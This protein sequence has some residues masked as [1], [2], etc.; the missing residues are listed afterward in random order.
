MLDL[1]NVTLSSLLFLNVQDDV[2]LDSSVELKDDAKPDDDDPIDAGAFVL[3]FAQMT[4]DNLVFER[5]DNMG[6]EAVSETE[7][8]PQQT[9]EV[10]TVNEN[11]AVA[12]INSE[13]YQSEANMSQ[14]ALISGADLNE[15][16][17]RADG[18]VEHIKALC[19]I[20]TADELDYYKN[21]GI[22]QYVLRN[23]A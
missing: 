18:K 5:E 20:D 21:G 19:R 1:N 3:L 9:Q 16:I 4:S 2:A 11:V 7:V 10:D 22:L 13:Y 15:T 23:I 14:T 6:S 12:W 8:V 17:E